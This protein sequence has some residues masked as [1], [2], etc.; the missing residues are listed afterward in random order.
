MD[1][2]YDDDDDYMSSK[3]TKSI[4][5][6]VDVAE[7]PEESQEVCYYTMHLT[8]FVYSH[9]TYRLK[10][11]N[12]TLK[13]KIKTLKMREMKKKWKRNFSNKKKE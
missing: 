1:D 3:Q 12:E 10:L 8:T 11:Q 2:Y 5:T 9:I 13:E 7:E 4:P 6:T